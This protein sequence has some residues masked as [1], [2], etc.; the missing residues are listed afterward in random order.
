MSCRPY[1]MPSIT[2]QVEINVDYILLLVEKMRED[3][4]QNDFDSA[5]QTRQ[6]ID[7]Q[8]DA[9]PTLRPRKD[10]FDEFLGHISSLN[11]SDESMSD[12]IEDETVGGKWVKFINR[13]REEEAAALISEMRLQP[14]PAKKFISASEENETGN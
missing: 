2:V 1:R 13:K 3:E 9:S 12:G 11:E 14:E 6:T 7:K 4:A 10:L 5:K 8:I